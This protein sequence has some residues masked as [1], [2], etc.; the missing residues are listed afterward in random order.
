MDF[1]FLIW[2]SVAIVA[3]GFFTV[4]GYTL[5]RISLL[6]L[7]FLIGFSIMMSLTASQTDFLRILASLTAGGLLG[8]LLFFFFRL[9]IYFAG[10]VLGLFTALFIISLLDFR[11]G[12]LLETA[13]VL[14]GLGAGSY[15]GR[16]LGELIIVIATAV[17]GAYS[18]VY[19]L[20]LIFPE[21]FDIDA[22]QLETLEEV[23][24]LQI[25]GLTIVLIATLGI[26]S[27]LAQYQILVLRRRL[28]RGA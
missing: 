1:T 26:T 18:I 28:G 7:G 16:Y 9:S 6:C 27:G 5:F 17:A 10:A 22:S 4:Y 25:S 14:A 21:F 20:T 8:A 15:F 13:A 2:G 23:G 24:R 3:G 19:G 11:A 12:G